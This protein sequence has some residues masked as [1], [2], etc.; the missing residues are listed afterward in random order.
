M[1]ELI[2][3]FKRRRMIRQMAGEQRDKRIVNLAQVRN[4]GI[5]FTLNS[6]HEWNLLYHFAQLMEEM[7]KKVVMIGLHPSNLQISFI[8]THAQTIIC[9]ESD[10]MNWW[11]IP[12]DDVIG[13]FT[14]QHLDVLIDTTDQP[15]FFGQYVALKSDADLKVT[16]TDEVETTRNDNI[17]DMM[18][19]GDGPL[20][21]RDY[22][23]QVVHYLK[24]V[25]KEDVRE[26]D[27]PTAQTEQ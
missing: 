19:K 24:M 3:D 17:Y 25:K 23:N 10:D 20:D 13:R 12:K 16:Y 5:V 21:M 8:V 6:E 4:I 2:K 9:R 18:I 27:A 11:G 7:G 22:L 14:D 1:L 26:N 15:N